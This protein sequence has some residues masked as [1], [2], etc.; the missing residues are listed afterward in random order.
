[1]HACAAH[2]KKVSVRTLRPSARQMRSQAAAAEAVAAVGRVVVVV[3]VVEE[4]EE[5]EEERLC[6]QTKAHKQEPVPGPTL[7]QA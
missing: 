7:Q 6:L 4:E 5:E 3:V 2:Q 1:M